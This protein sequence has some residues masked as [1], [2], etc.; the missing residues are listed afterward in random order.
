MCFREVLNTMN[1]TTHKSFEL[2]YKQRIKCNY[3]EHLYIIL[4]LTIW[5]GISYQR[6]PKILVLCL[7]E[8][9]S[10]FITFLLLKTSRSPSAKL[11]FTCRQLAASIAK[12]GITK[13]YHS[14]KINSLYCYAT[15]NHS[16][17]AYFATNVRLYSSDIGLAKRLKSPACKTIW[18]IVLSYS[19]W[20]WH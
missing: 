10:P 14:R 4:S 18:P 5:S 8:I 2:H 20:F 13:I 6:A 12:H 15:N 16:F 9:L 3:I 1:M 11:L 17:D 19:Y 7:I